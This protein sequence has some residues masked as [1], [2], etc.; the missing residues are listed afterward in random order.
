MHVWLEKRVEDVE[1]PSQILYCSGVWSYIVA[2]IATPTFII[3]P[4]ATI[5][6]GVF[7]IVLSFDAAIGLSVYY[8][9]TILVSGFCCI[10]AA[11]GAHAHQL[12]HPDMTQ[13][14][15]CSHVLLHFRNPPGSYP[16]LNHPLETT[17]LIQ[18][19]SAV[20]LLNCPTF[21]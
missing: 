7:P 3:V 14:S 20:V 8:V 17:S 1:L 16:D 21:R 11:V 18:Q 19:F 9:A 2:S 13:S 15:C 12:C 6:V 4:L 10:P 5:W